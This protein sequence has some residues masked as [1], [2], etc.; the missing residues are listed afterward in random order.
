MIP[1]TLY[2]SSQ[3]IRLKKNTDMVENKRY[4]L[5][6]LEAFHKVYMELYE[7]GKIAPPG[8]RWHCD[9]Q[10]CCSM[11][12]SNM[13]NVKLQRMDNKG[14]LN[15]QFDPAEEFDNE[16]VSICPA[17]FHDTDDYDYLS[18]MNFLP[19]NVFQQLTKQAL[20]KTKMLSLLFLCNTIGRHLNN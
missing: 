17:P 18:A 8:S 1:V 13:H 9:N 4:S 12:L 7:K 3:I 20:R 14:R 2:S 6:R 11:F 16:N 10:Y 19:I 15:V 5:V